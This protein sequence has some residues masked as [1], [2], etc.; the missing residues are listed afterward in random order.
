MQ[1]FALRAEFPASSVELRPGK[2]VWTGVLTPTSL[3]ASYT[4]RIEH[5]A[6][7]R[8]VVVVVDPILKPPQGKALP[9]VFRDNELCLYY[10]GEWDAS[11]PIVQTIVP[12][13]SEWLL[14][15]EIWVATGRWFGGGHA[16]PVAK[17]EDG[18]GD[19]TGFD[20]SSK[21]GE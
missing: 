12:W 18:L 1:A 4:L 19:S 11:R 15:Y 14:H 10:R 9:H 6:G 2:L 8:P 17:V 13:A 16:P 20:R 5:V 21:R 3:S 7:K